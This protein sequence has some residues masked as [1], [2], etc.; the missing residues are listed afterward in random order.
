VHQ[1]VLNTMKFGLECCI[2]LDKILTIK[3]AF[4]NDCGHYF[5][6]KCIF[7]YMNICNN[8]NTSE[9]GLC[10]LC[11]QRV[12]SDDLD[13]HEKYNSRHK[14]FNY[15]DK[16]ENFYNDDNYKYDQ[17]YCKSCKKFSAWKRCIFFPC[18][19]W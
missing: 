10:P 6:R 2:C 13:L 4:I 11:R 9:E 14:N 8:S 18:R 1:Q 16:L 3:T 7:K 17:Y 12:N 15:L 5:H 19:I